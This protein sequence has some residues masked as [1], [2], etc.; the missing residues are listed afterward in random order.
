MR[1]GGRAVREEAKREKGYQDQQVSNQVLDVLE[2]QHPPKTPLLMK[3]TRRKERKALL[4]S[5]DLP[6][7]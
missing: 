1:E 5:C 7:L 2:E 4:S 3:T 6:L